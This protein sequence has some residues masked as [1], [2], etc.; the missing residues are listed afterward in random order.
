MGGS[1]LRKIKIVFLVQRLVCGGAEQALFDLICLMDK[2]RFDIT[3]LALVDGGAWED[4]FRDAG[5]RVVSIFCR[6]KDHSLP[7]FVRHQ[8]K[9]LKIHW[10]IMRDSRKLLEMFLP[11]GADIAVAYSMWGD[12]AAA[13]ADN[14]LHVKYIHGNVVNNEAFRK[15]I[16][17]AR[18]LLS[19]YQR[20]VCV[21]EESCEGFKKVTGIE[22]NVRMLFNPL[23]SENVIRMAEKPVD[24]PVDVPVVCAVGRLAPEKA[25]DRL[26][27]IHKRLLD[28]GLVHRLVIVGDGE[29]KEKLLRIID[30]TETSD[31]VILAGYQSNPYPYMKLSRFLVCSSY[32]EGLPVTVMEALALG[33]PVVSSV[34]SIQE[35]FGEELC[36]VITDNDD[37]SLEQGIRKM[38]EDDRFYQQVKQGAQKRSAFFEGSQMV[39]AHEALYAELMEGRENASD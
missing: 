20:I 5:I 10:V 34:A 21:S 8:L 11:E 18:P 16:L 33:I 6:R 32:T 24:M 19:E 2:S 39:K 4:K 9:K 14:M 35:A 37:E 13:L 36:G 15:L 38:L 7:G 31:S 30:E 3:V 26:I 29:E 23:N 28:R 12:E 25:F 1:L 27:R 22:K 17:K